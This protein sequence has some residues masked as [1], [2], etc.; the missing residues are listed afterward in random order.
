ML[1]IK[2]LRDDPEPFRAGLTRRGM[3]GAVDELLAADENRRKPPTRV[4]ERL[5]TQNQASKAI[6]KADGD[7]KQR[8]IAEVG[9]VSAELKE[10]EPQLAD[11]E[12]ALN[13]LLESTATL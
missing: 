3:P 1:D 13:R 7:E 4:E 2:R 9:S 10:L 8:L 12:R 11:A 5:A 6:G